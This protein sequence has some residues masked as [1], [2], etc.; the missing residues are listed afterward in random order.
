[1]GFGDFAARRAAYVTA[2]RKFRFVR[3][4]I[5]TNVAGSYFRP[6]SILNYVA[7]I[8]YIHGFPDILPAWFTKKKVGIFSVVIGAK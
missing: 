1:M 4:N 5:S 2:K 7:A 3:G 6:S 8:F